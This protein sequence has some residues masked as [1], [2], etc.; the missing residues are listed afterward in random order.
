MLRV[1]VDFHGLTI[2]NLMTNLMTNL[3]TNLMTFLQRGSR[4]DGGAE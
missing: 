1:T 4:T 3:L 2:T